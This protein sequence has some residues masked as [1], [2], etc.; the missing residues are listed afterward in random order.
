VIARAVEDPIDVL[1]Q[2]GNVEVP[3][4]APGSVEKRACSGRPGLGP[5]LNARGL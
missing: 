3:G 2:A 1:L 4:D 5:E